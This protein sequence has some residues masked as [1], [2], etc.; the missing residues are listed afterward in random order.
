M[1]RCAPPCTGPGCGP[2]LPAASLLLLSL[3]SC[4]QG[5]GDSSPVQETVSV[6]VTSLHE[7]GQV[8]EQVSFNISY[9]RGQ[10]HLNG[11]PANR[12]VSRI[13][14]KMDLG[15]YGASSEHHNLTRK[16][17]VSIRLLVLHMSKNSSTG[18][19]RI[20]VQHEVIAIDG[21]KVNQNDTIELVFVV[22]KE[23]GVLRYSSSVI[24]L[25]ET[26]L[27]SIPWTNDVSFTFPNAPES[28]DSV[29]Q[30]TTREYNIG[31]NTTLEEE[32]FPGKLPETPLRAV[33]PASSY[34]VMCQIADDVR[35]KLCHI[36]FVLYPILVDLL[37]VVVFGVIGAAIVLELLKIVYPLREQKGILQ[38]NDLEESPKFVPL[39][40]SSTDTMEKGNI[41]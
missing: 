12:G 28:G 36:W 14:C 32:S 7:D 10:V 6:N 38:S 41:L 2:W 23:M 22:N 19:T 35:E 8:T 40:S 13:T 16:A 31:Q 37:Q 24:S 33:I 15:E 25:E 30:Q 29:P 1:V 4:G 20:I 26:W 5:S 9:S 21:N 34:K 27:H 39:L 11:F 3:L 18:V 17:L